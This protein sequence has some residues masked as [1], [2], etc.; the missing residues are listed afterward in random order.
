MKN[1]IKKI[2]PLCW[3]AIFGEIFFL[4]CCIFCVL[5]V[6]GGII[7]NTLF[8]YFASICSIVMFFG[9]LKT[10]LSFIKS[11]LIIDDKQISAPDDIGDERG[12]GLR[13]IQHKT[14]IY[15][16]EIEDIYICAGT[17]DSRGKHIEGVFNAMPYLV[18]VCKNNKEK[19]INIYYFSKKQVIYIIN[20]IIRR[21]AILG[22]CFQ[23]DSG[24]EMLAKFFSKS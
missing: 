17:F 12:T 21:A 22:N 14:T 18:F 16:D 15:F 8:G 5:G 20:E 10:F 9:A 11:R 2:Y 24:E 19:M 4:G 7:I 1:K 3:I 6:I 23:C 13:K